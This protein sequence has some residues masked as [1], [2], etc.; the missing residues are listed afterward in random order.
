[1]LDLLA[2][3]LLLDAEILDLLHFG[4]VFFPLLQIFVLCIPPNLSLELPQLIFELDCL[5]LL[6]L[7]FAQLLHFDLLQI[8]QSYLLVIPLVLINVE[9]VQSLILD[10]L[11]LFGFLEF[12]HFLES[13]SALIHLVQGLCQLYLSQ[14]A[15]T[16]LNHSQPF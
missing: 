9:I 8:F 1:M 10:L 7:L 2:I 4:A 11:L 6:V 16:F 13:E 12:T 14:I 3:D 15:T 5:L